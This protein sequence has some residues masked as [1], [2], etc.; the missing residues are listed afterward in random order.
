MSEYDQVLHE[1]GTT[2]SGLIN[3][4]NTLPSCFEGNMGIYCHL[5]VIAIII[6]VA[7]SEYDQV[8]H[9]DETTLSGLINI[10]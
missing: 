9:E 1:E 4:N 3:S 7:M 6:C 5:D 8:L 10:K 2:V